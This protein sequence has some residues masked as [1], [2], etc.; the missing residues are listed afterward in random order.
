[1]KVA[2]GVKCVVITPVSEASPPSRKYIGDVVIAIRPV[3]G[4]AALLLHTVGEHKLSDTFWYVQ[5]S[6][7]MVLHCVE[8]YLL[9]LPPQDVADK[10][11]GKDV[12]RPQTPER[13]LDRL[14]ESLERLQRV[15]FVRETTYGTDP[16]SPP[17]RRL[18]PR[19]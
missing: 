2:P 7:G 17:F 13:I 10:M 1:V 14:H 8:R 11:F 18:T 3:D 19:E 16:V 12:S 6:D 9:P 4:Q 15:R 5:A